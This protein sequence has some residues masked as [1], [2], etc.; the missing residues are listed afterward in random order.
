LETA[1]RLG[2][3]GTVRNLANGDVEIIATGTEQQLRGL[4]DWCHHGPSRASVEKVF[5]ED[6][7]VQDANNFKIVR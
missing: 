1:T 6:L 4:I 3:T 5:V 2:V 7:P